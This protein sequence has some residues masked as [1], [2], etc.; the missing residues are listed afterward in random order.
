MALVFIKLMR[1]SVTSEA[2]P[3]PFGTLAST[4]K[5]A[6]EFWQRKS[7]NRLVDDQRLALGM[8]ALNP[9]GLTEAALLAN[10]FV[11]TCWRVLC[12]LGLR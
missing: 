8:L 4:P 12:L 9:R 10:A 1:A 3:F 2:R 5:L 7:L 11:P 6:L